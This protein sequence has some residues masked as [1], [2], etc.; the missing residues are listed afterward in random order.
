MHCHTHL[1]RKIGGTALFV[2]NGVYDMESEFVIRQLGKCNYPSPLTLSTY[3]RDT[4]GVLLDAV[5]D[6]SSIYK[7]S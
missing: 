7:N 2:F 3:V 4:D 5:V 6:S 1:H